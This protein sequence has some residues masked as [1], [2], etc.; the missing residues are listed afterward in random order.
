VLHLNL[1]LLINA[2]QHTK[3]K[4]SG[5]IRKPDQTKLG[6]GVSVDQIISAQQGLIPQMAGFLTSKGIW[7]C[8]TFIDRVSDYMYV[9]LMKDFTIMEPLLAKLAF[10]KLCAKADCSVKHYQAD[11][12][13][14][15]DKEFLTACNNL[16]QT[17]EF[18]R[19]GAHHQK[20][21]VENRNKKLTQT[22]RVL[23]LHGMRMWPHMIYQMFLP[24]AIKA[25][26]ER[27]NSLHIDTDGHTPESKFYGVNIKN[28]PVK[29]FHAMFCPCYILDSRL[30][31]VGSIGPPKWEP[32]SNICVYLGHSLFH[33]RSIALVYNP[34]T[35]YVS[36][37]NNVVF[38][39]DFTMVLY[40]KAGT[41]PPHW[42]VLVHSS[43]ELASKHALNLAQAWLGS[44]SQDNTDLQFTD[45]PVI[46][47]FAIVTDHHTSNIT[48]NTH[49]DQAP[50]ITYQKQLSMTAVLPQT[51]MA[52]SKGGT[53][54]L[55]SKHPLITTDDSV[56]PASQATTLTCQGR[57]LTPATISEPSMAQPVDEIKLP[58]GLNLRESGLR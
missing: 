36:P 48:K 33:A 29:T 52:V 1:A 50:Y 23:F 51:K 7:G 11:N 42:S 54:T 43:S 45:N 5:S 18:C 12:G 58:P 35:G 3:G 55:G 53:L 57:E 4:K 32:R 10:K 40:M 31:N 49:L 25:A 19:V 47:P 27:M 28:I 13:Q 39:D 15:S 30:H 16:N 37:Q 14:I 41:I 8:T 56:C 26:A 38:D 22:A 9:H 34:S 24:F 17:I 21:I 44:T 46:D 2:L 6:D 20:R